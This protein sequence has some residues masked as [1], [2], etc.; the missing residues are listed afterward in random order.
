MTMRLVGA[1]ALVGL[2]LVWGASR[3]LSPVTHGVDAA[4]YASAEKDALPV[5][6]VVGRAAS[7]PDRPPN[8]V[9]ILADDLGWGDLGVQGS[10]AIASPNLDALAA[11]GMRLT[12][13]YAS[14]PVCSPSRAGLLTGR[15]PLRSGFTMALPMARDSWLRR[16]T[17]RGSVAF[18]KLGIV[19]TA[20]GD[21]PVLGLPASEI[22]LAEALRVAGYRTMAIGKWHLGD[23][24][25]HDE[26]HPSRH[27]FDHF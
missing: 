15:Y 27:G 4:A 22:T 6:R 18:A 8:L 26:F 21:G 12:E 7:A 3:L 14:A 24:S 10:R 13:F 25:A 17:R 9:V 1:L 2:A 20:G 11:E 19:D 5:A 23:F 16:V